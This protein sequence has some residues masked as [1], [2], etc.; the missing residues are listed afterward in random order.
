MIQRFMSGLAMMFL[1][2]IT[3]VFR[4]MTWSSLSAN[5]LPFMARSAKYQPDHRPA[6]R[7]WWRPHS[8]HGEGRF[9]KAG[10]KPCGFI[11]GKLLPSKVTRILQ[12]SALF[13]RKNK[14]NSS[15]QIS[16]LSRNTQVQKSVN[17]NHWSPR[18][19]RT[20]FLWHPKPESAYLQFV[21]YS[22]RR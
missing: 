7:T 3:E 15:Q 19:V 20:I 10:C 8:G 16:F 1:Q 2:K 12:Q 21:V 13:K 6:P 14:R 4:W 18:K 9:W 5:K 17:L 22:K 11:Q